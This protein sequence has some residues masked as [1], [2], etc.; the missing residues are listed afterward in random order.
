MTSRSNFLIKLERILTEHISNPSFSGSGLADYM[1]M[2]RMH[3]HR[4][5]RRYL[6]KTSSEVIREAR[7]RLAKKLIRDPAYNIY[8]V[9]RRSGFKDPAYFSRVFRKENGMSPSRYR[10]KVEEG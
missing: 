1:G 5:L 10:Y 3:L 9:A 8:E 7:M 4:H 6:N 2:S